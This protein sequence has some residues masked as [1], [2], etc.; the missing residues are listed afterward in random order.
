MRKLLS[1]LQIGLFSLLL[2]CGLP[3]VNADNSDFST[4]IPTIPTLQVNVKPG[5]N[6]TIDKHIEVCGAG[7]QKSTTTTGTLIVNYTTG[8]NGERLDRVRVKLTNSSG[9]SRLYF[10]KTQTEDSLKAP[11]CNLSIPGL[12]PG[13][14]TI[15]FLIPNS[16]GLFAEIPPQTIQI[17][18]H[19]KSVIHQ[20]LARA[21]NGLK[22]ENIS[23]N[24]SAKN[25]TKNNTSTDITFLNI[26]LPQQSTADSGAGAPNTAT[27]AAVK[28]TPVTITYDTGPR[29]D[30]LDRVR[31]WVIN[32]SGK[33]TMYPGCA[34]INRDPNAHTYS[35]SINDLP[36]GIYSLEFVVPNE[37]GL[38]KEVPKQMFAVVPGKPVSL[39]ASFVPLYGSIK[40]S[41]DLSTLEIEDQKALSV[42]VTDQF[43]AVIASSKT[44]ELL[45]QGLPPGTYTLSFAEIIGYEKPGP[46][47]IKINPGVAAAPFIAKYKDTRAALAVNTNR[48]DATW[49]LTCQGK[50]IY[51]GTRSAQK[52]KFPAGEGYQLQTEPLNG[53]A[54]TVS[55][56]ETFTL[57]QEAP[58]TATIAYTSLH[59]LTVKTNRSEALFTLTDKEGK[60]LGEGQGETF[61]FKGV[62]AGAYRLN[63]SSTDTENLSPPVPIKVSVLDAGAS[64]KAD[65]ICLA[66]LMISSNAS[67]YTISLKPL[68]GTARAPLSYAI[69]G[70]RKTI[71]APEGKYLLSFEPLCGDATV[72][73]V[74]YAPAPIEVTLRSSHSEKVHGV[75]ETAHGSL[76]VSCNLAQAG[77]TVTEITDQET[78]TIGHFRG[79]QTIIPL[80]FVGTYQ[81]TFDDIPR[82]RTPSPVTIEIKAN[83]RQVAGGVYLFVQPVVMIPTG[84]VI[85]GDVFGEGA[86]DEKPSRAVDLNA[87]SIGITAVT[88]A[89]FAAWLTRAH[90]EGKIQYLQRPE[91]SKGVVIDRDG[92]VLFK[93]KHAAPESQIEV[94][95][96]A[97]HLAFKVVNGKE[98]FPVIEVS[99]YGAQLYCKENGGRLPTEAEWEKAA[100]MAFTPPNKPLKKYRY[101]FGRDSIDIT[102]ANYQEE[103]KKGKTPTVDTTPVGF[104]DGINLLSYDPG[105]DNKLRTNPFLLQQKHGTSLARSP[106]GAYDMSGNVRE[107]T[108][109]WYGSDYYKFIESVNPKGLRLGSH[110]VTKGGSYL[111]YAYGVRVAARQPLTPE[112]TD[113]FT[114]FRIVIDIT[115]AITP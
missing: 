34:H 50:S 54:A 93:T 48:D 111:S 94:S 80:T 37:D 76:A 5:E 32:E 69:Q 72:R 82:Y 19:T 65:Y 2:M 109:D 57:T 61:T 18:A 107:W 114:G 98:A 89:E 112:T 3:V 115:D 38:F 16:D 87:F 29:E 27:P 56:S 104:Y 46:V 108:N 95:T 97:G 47:T 9:K 110:K 113:A 15:E 90:E 52:T 84:P 91:A 14:Y 96:A 85:V 64:V 100:G 99:W 13:Q 4:N 26:S 28:Q 73:Y 39:R 36:F 63:F 1:S 8:A 40:A 79:S 106:S 35:V 17:K 7:K 58:L 103:F 23:T 105:M 20:E 60:T 21:S 49:T 62:P 68:N 102:C 11:T 101:G 42:T 41:I 74:A 81:V 71:S 30:R 24:A 88:N 59:T 66:T 44:A 75:Y 86:A 12:A 67:D 53:Y 31:F 51:S 92:N 33:R 55:P 43:G 77:Y 78:L 45:T 25:H 83:E 70:S 22:A 10:S 6:V